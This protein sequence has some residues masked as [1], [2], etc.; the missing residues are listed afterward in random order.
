MTACTTST[1]SI[2]CGG[3]RG[4]RPPVCVQIRAASCSA[5]TCASSGSWPPHAS[6]SRSAP[7]AQTARATERVTG[8]VEQISRACEDVAAVMSGV[9]GTVG[10]MNGLSDG[11]AEA[12]D[13]TLS[14]GLADTEGAGLSRMAEQLRS[15]A[16]SFLGE[17]R[18]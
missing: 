7:S 4:A 17:M 12:V 2:R 5:A 6:L 8:Q 15:E 14:A 3:V 10:E 16:I 13:G 9:G 18:R 1:Y 11:I